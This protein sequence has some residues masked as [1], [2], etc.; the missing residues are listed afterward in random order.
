M[1]NIADGITLSTA[2]FALPFSALGVSAFSV[3]AIA[4]GGATMLSST[5]AN[6]YGIRHAFCIQ[7]DQYPG[8]SNCTF[9]TYAQCLASASG[10][11][12]SC[13]ANPYFGGESDDPYASYQNRAR[14]FPQGYIP[15][16]PNPYWYR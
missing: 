3:S 7:G 4:L 10:R 11:S 15:A 9:D 16:P 14:R 5:P 6:A 8:L 12:L 13:I 2:R 1:R